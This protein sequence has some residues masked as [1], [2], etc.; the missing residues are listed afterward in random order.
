MA[1]IVGFIVAGLFFSA[2]HYFTELNKLQKIMITIALL[3]FISGAI[4]FNAYSQRQRQII[5]T[6]VIKFNQ[7]KTVD[8]DGIDVNS[9]NYTLSIG[10]YTFIGKKNTPFYGQ[11]VSA[12]QCK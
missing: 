8:C 3:I 7:N 6:V 1:Y 10:T 9:T 4:A 2:M 12:Y 5:E 11:M